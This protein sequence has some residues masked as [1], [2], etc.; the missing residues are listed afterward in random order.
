MTVVKRYVISGI[1]N[2]HKEA[3]NF[4]LFQDRCRGG[5]CFLH[6]TFYVT[7]PWPRVMCQQVLRSCG[8]FRGLVHLADELRQLR[9]EGEPMHC[10]VCAA[11]TSCGS[12]TSD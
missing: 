9:S 7:L 6:P 8:A 12:T 4:S 1:T 10:P 2:T 11:S 3:V 5:W